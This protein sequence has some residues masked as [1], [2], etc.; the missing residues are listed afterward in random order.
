MIILEFVGKES[1][2]AA[3][4]RELR[5]LRLR[6]Q[7]NTKAAAKIQAFVRGCLCRQRVS[8]K[9]AQLI[10]ELITRFATVKIQALPASYHSTPESCCSVKDKEPRPSHEEKEDPSVVKKKSD[11][12]SEKDPS[13]VK[14]KSDKDSEKDANSENSESYYRAPPASKKRKLSDCSNHIEYGL[15][16]HLLIEEPLTA[17]SLHR[18]AT[19]PSHEVQD[20]TPEKTLNPAI[21]HKNSYQGKEGYPIAGQK[22]MI[23]IFQAS[24]L[25]YIDANNEP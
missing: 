3:T 14:K 21:D 2:T 19:T 8:D 4:H 22:N 20:K 5:R 13:V 16:Q 17:Q 11:K 15:G 24:P 23:K 12:D 7:A 25:A 18:F 1:R 10:T 6:Q 9:V